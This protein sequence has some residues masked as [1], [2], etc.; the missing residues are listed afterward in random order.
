M[1]VSV[2]TFYASVDAGYVILGYTGF[3]WFLVSS[4]LKLSQVG[5]PWGSVYDIYVP[6]FTVINMKIPHVLLCS[7]G[8][9]PAPPPKGAQS[10]QNEGRGE[11]RGL[12]YI[13][14]LN[15]FFKDCPC[16]V[17]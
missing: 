11:S 10:A 17:H 2:F 5:V 13:S 12:K 4:P 7:S 15:D 6:T 14:F 16:L 1:Q 8:F 3:M 9:R